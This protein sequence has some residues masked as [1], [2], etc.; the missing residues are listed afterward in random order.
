LRKQT[1]NVIDQRK[2]RVQANLQKE[3]KLRQQRVHRLN[4]G[5]SADDADLDQDT[6]GLGALSRFK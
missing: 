6:E 3:K 4:K 1:A 5:L 2:L